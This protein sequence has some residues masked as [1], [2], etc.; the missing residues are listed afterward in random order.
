MEFLNN[1]ATWMILV[2]IIGY[3]FI[4]LEYI[5]DINKATIALLMAIICWAIQFVYAGA[6]KSSYFLGNSL[7]DIS[8]LVFFLIGA[9]TVVEI[10]AA[11]DGFRFITDRIQIESKM[12]MFWVIGII[13]FFLSAI[14]DNLATT[15]VMVSLLRKLLKDPLDRFIMGSGVVI[16]ANAGG[17]WSPIGD[18]TTTMLWI[19]GEISS[20]EIMKGLFLP[21]LISMA[22]SFGLLSPLLKNEK[23]EVIHDEAA[24][25]DPLSTPIFILGVS[26]LIFVPLF[27]AITGLPPFMGILF[28]L[29]VMWLVTDLLHRREDSEQHLRVHALFSKIDLA[30]AL[31]FLGLL[32]AINALEVVGVL[33]SLAIWLDKTIPNIQVMAGLMGIFSAVI[34][35]VPF[36][37]ASIGMYSLEQYPAD[38][39]LWQL[40]AYCS[41]T[42][43]SI[44]ITGSAAGVALMG[45]EKIDFFWYLRKISLPALLG[46]IAGILVYMVQ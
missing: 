40:I 37:A 25:K 32:L 1:P 39:M 23:L 21:S 14:L 10:I 34:G 2:F 35:N 27:T 9:L 15:V 7:T 17:A 4:A 46:Y 28:G 43:G 36:V 42:G 26:S 30:A 20:F 16:A 45:M 19:D 41:G 3:S 6:D 33:H 8:Q 12:K 22:V 29:S 18:V 38:S 11:H 13:T 44:L 24:P 31:F 5:T